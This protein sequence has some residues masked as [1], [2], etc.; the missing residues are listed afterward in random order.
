ML[1]EKTR[2][3]PHDAGSRVFRTTGVGYGLARVAGG[4]LQVLRQHDVLATDDSELGGLVQ[5]EGELPLLRRGRVLHPLG[6]EA[7][8]DAGAGLVVEETAELLERLALSR[9]TLSALLGGLELLIGE[10]RVV[11]RV[12]AARGE[13]VLATA[14]PVLALGVVGLV[15]VSQVAPA[16]EVAR[17]PELL[18]VEAL[19]GVVVRHAPHGAKRLGPLGDG[20]GTSHKNS[21]VVVDVDLVSYCS[22][23]VL[24]SQ[25]A[26]TKTP[27]TYGVFYR[28]KCGR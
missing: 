27:H 19:A 24:K 22:I 1:C 15:A 3:G 8:P 12:P 9:A 18:L 16:H 26:Y 6:V 23:S 25:Y 14:T 17:V 5:R 13:I 10:A 2:G 28:D 21:F 20:G 4:V 11:V 7:R